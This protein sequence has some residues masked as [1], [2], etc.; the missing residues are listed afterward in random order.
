MRNDGLLEAGSRAKDARYRFTLPLS[1]V[2][3][4]FAVLTRGDEHFAIAASLVEDFLVDAPIDVD[5]D[6]HET[7]MLANRSLP[8]IDLS[9]ISPGARYQREPGEHVVIFGSVEKRLA[10]H[11]DGSLEIHAMPLLGE[12][13]E[14]WEAIAHSS[15]ELDGEE[16]PILDVR[17][18]LRQRF[19]SDPS[20]RI[21]HRPTADESIDSFVPVPERPRRV[22]LRALLVNQSEFRRRELMRTLQ[23]QGLSA[24]ATSSLVEARHLLAQD[25]I[26]LLVS[27]LRLGEEGQASF[28]GLREE[29]PDL[30]II[31][32]TSVAESYADDVAAKSQAHACWRD[33]FR[34]SDFQGILADLRELGGSPA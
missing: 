2:H 17:A 8:L 31:L 14:G 23:N 4:R 32:T 22:T 20:P 1:A 21:S 16:V 12:T 6:G 25:R 7:L 29:H 9:E 15:L 3:P 13:P 28:A 27:D 19:Q 5:E 33:P 18:L 34:G 24:Q 10:V 11:C 26:D 30:K